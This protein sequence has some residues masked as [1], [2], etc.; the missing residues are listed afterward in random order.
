MGQLLRQWHR[1]IHNH[2]TTLQ[3]PILHTGVLG[4]STEKNRK[5]VQRVDLSRLF[6][7]KQEQVAE[8]LPDGRDRLPPGQYHTKKWPILTYEPTPK[9]DPGAYRFKVWG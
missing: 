8:K 7:Q 3:R 1:P 4:V 5:K 9:F 2:S 6:G